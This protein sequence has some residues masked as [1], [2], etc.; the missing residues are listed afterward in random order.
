MT[1]NGDD[2]GPRQAKGEYPPESE[3]PEGCGKVLVSHNEAK[4]GIE[5]RFPDK[6]SDA[7]RTELKRMGFKWSRR[8]A[9][10]YKRNGSAVLSFAT[11]LAERSS[12]PATKPVTSVESAD[13]I[14]AA[15]A[16]KLS[17]PARDE[18]LAAHTDVDSAYE[19]QCEEATT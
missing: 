13:Q 5:I 6:P 7:T 11:G 16:Y 17:A 2:L 9:C 10:W 15:M 18:G 3:R 19:R 8:S 14:A 4:H 1:W 12:L